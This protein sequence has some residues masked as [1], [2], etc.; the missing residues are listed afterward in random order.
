[1]DMEYHSLPE[2]MLIGF[3]LLPGFSLSISKT[4]VRVLLT[5][6]NSVSSI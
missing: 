3:N 2:W 4:T 1:M 5:A 6:L